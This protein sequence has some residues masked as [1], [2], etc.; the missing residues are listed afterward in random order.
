M[1]VERSARRIVRG[2]SHVVL[3]IPAKVAVTAHALV[4]RLTGGM[5]ALANRLLPP[6]G[7]IGRAHA[8][9]HA[10]GSALSPSWLTVL[11]ERAARKYNQT[12]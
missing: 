6:P 11:G 10:S 1:S 5:L 12:A 2:Q 4:P 9:G 8:P 7:G 3:S